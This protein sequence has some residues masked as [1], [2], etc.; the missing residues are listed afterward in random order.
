MT[1]LIHFGGVDYRWRELA[2]DPSAIDAWAHP[3]IAVLRGGLVAVGAPRSGLLYLLDASGQSRHTLTTSLT[4]IHGITATFHGDDQ[5]LWLADNGRKFVPGV[6]TYE[7]AETVGRVVQVDLAGVIHRE[8]LQPQAGGGESA[9]RPTS[10]ALLAPA[11]GDHGRIWVAD[12]YGASLVH[13]YADDGTHRYTLDGTE[14]GT[15]FQ[16]PHAL[17]LTTRHGRPELYVADRENHRVVVFDPDGQYL[18]VIGEGALNRPSGLADVQSQ[19]VV[20]ELTGAL[21]LFDGEDRVRDR[22]GDSRVAE[23]PGWPNELHDGRTRR[24]LLREGIF[25]SPHAVA[26]DADG[27]IYVTEWVIGGRLI[28][29]EVAGPPGAA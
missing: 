15:R 11:A 28:K 6:S 18:R 3:G 25:N 4:E 5:R 8:L 27:N 12:G 24:P 13:C 17:L 10:I 2:L 21:V 9:W 23:R 29:L 19:L 1:K 22:V 20:S 16:T 7:P 14:A 26:A